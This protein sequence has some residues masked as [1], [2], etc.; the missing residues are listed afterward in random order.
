MHAN[1]RWFGTANMYAVK[2]SAIQEGSTQVAQKTKKERE[3][4]R[5]K[6]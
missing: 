2:I 5:E 3:K 6:M 4:E 1:T